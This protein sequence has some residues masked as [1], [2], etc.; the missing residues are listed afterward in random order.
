MSVDIL[1]LKTL[2]E[3]AKRNQYDCLALNDYG[4]AVPPAVVLELITEIERHRQVEAEGCKPD[5]INLDC[6]FCGGARHDYFG[7]KCLECQPPADAGGYP[8]DPPGTVYDG[9]AS[10]LY[11]ALS[12]SEATYPL[13]AAA[14]D[15]LKERQRQINAEGYSPEQDDLHVRGELADAGSVYAF[16]ARTCDFGLASHI[17]PSCWPWAPE[18]WKPTNQ[19]QMLI[20]AGALILAELE[21]LDRLQAREVLND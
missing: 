12:A 19:R 5:L 2:A 9:P 10:A 16:W 8:N 14:G 1:K 3:A 6:D 18:H 15:L 17:P 21:R 11:A 13:S 20:R 7:D 4:T